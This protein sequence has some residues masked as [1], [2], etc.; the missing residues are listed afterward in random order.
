VREGGTGAVFVDELPLRAP[1]LHRHLLLIG[2]TIKSIVVRV[3]S[4][5]RDELVATARR[6]SG[7]ESMPPWVLVALIGTARSAPPR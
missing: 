5:E 7:N 3:K 4:D 2:I 1:L 6:K